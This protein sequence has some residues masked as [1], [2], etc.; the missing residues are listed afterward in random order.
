MKW[1]AKTVWT[2]QQSWPRI[3]SAFER[4]HTCWS[5]G[6]GNQE[7]QWNWIVTKSLRDELS[8]YSFQQPEERGLEFTGI[9]SMYD[10]FFKELRPGEVFQKYHATVPV[11]SRQFFTG[12]SRNAAPLWWWTKVADCLIAYYCKRS[13]N[14]LWWQWSHQYSTIWGAKGLVMCCTICVCEK[15]ARTGTVES[16]QAMAILKAGKLDCINDSNKACKIWF[17]VIEPWW[18]MVNYRASSKSGFTRNRNCYD[19]SQSY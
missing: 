9:K 4:Q 13:K 10:G 19:N 6:F 2:T 3:H 18:A 17:Q 1:S 11:K 7:I 16:Q 15:Y 12:L 8:K 5:C 14:S